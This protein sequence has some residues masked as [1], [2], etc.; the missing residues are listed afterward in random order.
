MDGSRVC[1][2]R[3]SAVLINLTH[4]LKRPHSA[5]SNCG[6]V[7]HC[8]RIVLKVHWIGRFDLALVLPEHAAVSKDWQLGL[9]ARPHHQI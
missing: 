1:T 5:L 4:V 7:L 2:R 3:R 8:P 9:R 6:R